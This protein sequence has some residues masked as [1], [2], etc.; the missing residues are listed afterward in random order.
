M[1]DGNRSD[2]HW[3]LDKRIPLTLVVLIIGQTV[4]AFV[5][6]ANIANAVASLE[7]RV[8]TLESSEK[9]RAT[10]LVRLSES[11]ARLDERSRQQADLLIEIKAQLVRLNDRAA[12]VPMPPLR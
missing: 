5:W 8:Q 3:T 7:G 12:P 9:D 6:A 10:N 2:N 4:G 1:A 11:L